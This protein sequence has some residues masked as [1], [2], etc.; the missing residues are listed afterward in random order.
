MAGTIPGLLGFIEGHNAAE[1]GTYRRNLR[2]LSGMASMAGNAL[3]VH[4]EY[5]PSPRCNL[6]RWLFPAIAKPP[7]HEMQRKIGILFQVLRSRVYANL[8]ARIEQLL[9]WI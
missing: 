9:P 3:A 8:S 5:H 2:E 4:G 1:M 7:G 6:R